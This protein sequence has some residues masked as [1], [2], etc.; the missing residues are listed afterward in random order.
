MVKPG[1]SP[2][3]KNRWSVVGGRWATRWIRGLV[4]PATA[5]PSRRI[6]TFGQV[7]CR[8]PVAP[9]RRPL[10]NTFGQVPC[11][12]GRDDGHIRDGHIRTGTMLLASHPGGMADLSRG[13]A[14]IVAAR[15]CRAA[16][17][18]IRPAGT[19][20]RRGA[21]SHGIP[22][23]SVRCA[24]N[25]FG[26]VPCAVVGGGGGTMVKTKITKWFA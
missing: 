2:S 6:D 10:G 4:T 16:D 14:A 12:T 5:V 25:T 8:S 17:P 18:R 9:R 22:R 24:V 11:A 3:L 19:A 23:A 15:P 1:F 13:S 20:P 7:P 21:R 26:Q